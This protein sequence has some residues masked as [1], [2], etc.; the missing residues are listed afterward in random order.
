MQ[1]AAKDGRLEALIESIESSGFQSRPSAAVQASLVA[2]AESM[3]RPEL[4]NGLRRFG[5][6]APTSVGPVVAANQQV[7][8]G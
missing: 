8:D 4:V 1:R 6:A 7:N 5:H 2:D 3:Q